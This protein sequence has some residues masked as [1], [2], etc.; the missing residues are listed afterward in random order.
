[1]FVLFCLILK[2]E[3][4]IYFCYNINVEKG[5]VYMTINIRGNKIEITDSM[6]NYIEEK[7]GKVEKYFDNPFSILFTSLLISIF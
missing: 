6:K 1:M 2:F 5:C 3:K 7:V 4:S